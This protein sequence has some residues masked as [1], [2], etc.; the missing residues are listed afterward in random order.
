MREISCNIERALREIQRDRHRAF[1]QHPFVH[2]ELS[3]AVY[4]ERILFREAA[5][6]IGAPSY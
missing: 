6:F 1:H 3:Q 2:L 5:G 4:V